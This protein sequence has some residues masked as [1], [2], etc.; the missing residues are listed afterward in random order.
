MGFKKKSIKVKQIQNKHW[1]NEWY[2]SKDKK[3]NQVHKKGACS[4]FL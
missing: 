1:K 3:N 2:I 4:A